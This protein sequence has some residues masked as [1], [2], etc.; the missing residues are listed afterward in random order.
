METIDSYFFIVYELIFQTQHNLLSSFRKSDSKV[1][2]WKLR[3]IDMY[4][5]WFKS[6]I[7]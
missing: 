1:F 5:K 6:E 2:R 3:I 4:Q 7:L